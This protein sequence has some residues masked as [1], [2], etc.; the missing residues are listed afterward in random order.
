MLVERKV[1]MTGEL[2]SRKTQ[3]MSV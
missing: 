1:A 3:K 2:A